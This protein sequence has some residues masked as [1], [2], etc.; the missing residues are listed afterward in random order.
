MPINQPSDPIGKRQ[1]DDMHRK[2]LDVVVGLLESYSP[3]QIRDSLI[4][5]K[6]GISRITFQRHFS[7]TQDAITEATKKRM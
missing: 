2:I 4:I 1:Y 3:E 6:A 7:S 5:G